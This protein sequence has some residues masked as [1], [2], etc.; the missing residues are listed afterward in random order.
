MARRR[1]RSRP[2]PKSNV[3]GI[4]ILIVVSLATL[5]AVSAGILLTIREEPAKAEKLATDPCPINPSEMTAHTLVLVDATEGFEPVRQER[6][7]RLINMLRTDLPPGGRITITS[8]Y[9]DEYPYYP[10]EWGTTCRPVRDQI[11]QS[12]FQYDS[13]VNTFN[14]SINRELSAL[15]GQ[16][17]A[18]ISPIFETLSYLSQ[19]PDFSNEIPNRRLVVI[20]DL[21]QHMPVRGNR[22]L[23][24]TLI[25]ASSHPADFESVRQS[26]YFQTIP[27]PDWTNTNI[28]LYMV[29]HERWQ[30]YQAADTQKF[31]EQYFGAFGEANLNWKSLGSITPAA[32]RQPARS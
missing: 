4:A 25:Q 23:G 18:P 17:E 19:R 26:D 2:E 13:Q 10:K 27:D 1:F 11:A 21:L 3:V 16:D 29:R 24:Y 30:R 22:R 5:G 15:V 32:P 14:T 6:I 8:V 20:S 28:E 7:K 12:K 31:W 9:S